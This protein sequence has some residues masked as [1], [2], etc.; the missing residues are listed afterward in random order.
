MKY[1]LITGFLGELRDRFTSYQP[2]RDITEK[3]R[4]ASNIKNLT[5]LELIYPQDFNDLELVKKLLSDYNF[6]VSAINLNIKGESKWRYGAFTA[7]NEETRKEAIKYLKRGME[8]AEELGANIV[9][10]CPLN[11][12]SD[13]PFEIDYRSAWENTVSCIRECADFKPTV[14]I[15]IEY[16][17]CEPRMHVLVRDAGRAT[18]LAKVIDRDN[19]G[20]TLDV[21]HAFEAGEIPAESVDILASVDKLFYVH[22]NDNFR[23]WDWDMIPGTVNTLEMVEFIYVLKSVGYDSWLTID[24]YPWRFDP[25]KV[26]SETI[27]WMEHCRKISEKIDAKILKDLQETADAIEVLRYI[28]SLL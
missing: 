8:I 23:N 1:S 7:V 10:V 2:S 17:T 11:D 3:F 21:G 5:G 9:T 22:I 6:E 4:L 16:K 26:F 27:E 15:S 25:V 24:V 12:G 20:V 19:V 28:R 18:L 14:K 13:Y